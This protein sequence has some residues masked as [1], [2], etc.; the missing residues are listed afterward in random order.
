MDN[1][2]LELIKNMLHSSTPGY[3]GVIGIFTFFV[4]I[5]AAALYRIKEGMNEEQH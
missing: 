1:V 2:L 5:V 4:A 3:F